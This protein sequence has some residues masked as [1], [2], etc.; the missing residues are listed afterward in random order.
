MKGQTEA[1]SKTVVLCVPLRADDLVTV[2][3]A[4]YGVAVR[5]GF[6]YEAIEDLKVAVTEA[7]N[8]AILQAGEREPLPMLRLVFTLRETELNIRIGT[9]SPDVTFG[10]ALHP[11]KLPPEGAEALERL[12]DSPIGLYLLQALVDELRVEPGG[13]GASEAIVLSKRLAAG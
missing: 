11:V 3:L 6:S 8:Y 2:R 13:G 1:G 4:L 7:C 5:V 12:E 9:D 10:E